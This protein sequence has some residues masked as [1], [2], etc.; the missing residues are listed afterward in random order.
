MPIHHNPVLR[1][2]LLSC[3]IAAVV[4]SL[5]PAVAAADGL[6]IIINTGSIPVDP[7]L[8]GT[9]TAPAY[10]IYA[11]DLASGSLLNSG[12]ITAPYYGIFALSM[13]G[14]SLGNTGHLT[15]GTVEGHE[16][17]GAWGLFAGSL[18]SGA[19]I[20]NGGT[21][22]VSAS[23]GSSVAVFGIG[24]GDLSGG[25]SITNAGAI[26][27]TADVAGNQVVA[28]G[29]GV[30][31][32]THSYISNGGDIAATARS[33]DGWL[34]ACGVCLN[35]VDG[36][37][38]FNNSGTITASAS[39][40][41]ASATGSAYG[42]YVRELAAGATFINTGTIVA[43]GG[44]ALDIR[45][46]SV[47]GGDGTVGNDGDIRGDVALGGTV[48][49]VN[50]GNLELAAGRGSHVGG[51]Y[52]QVA[53]GQLTVVV[54][55]ALAYGHVDVTGTADL[56]ASG[57]LVVQL[58]PALQLASGTVLAN[59]VT[60]GTL[61]APAG[62]Y[63]IVDASPF[64]RFAAVGDATHVDIVAARVDAAT[65]L[66]GSGVAFT[67]SQ[68]ALVDA[69]VEG[70][71]GPQYVALAG[72]LNRAATA[73]AAAAIVRQLDPALAGAAGRAAQGASQ[74]IGEVVQARQAG[75]GA[76]S[77]DEVA[78]NGVWLKT[79]IGSAGQD[80]VA[81][82][83]GFSAD[84]AGLVLGMDGNVSDDWRLGVAVATA[85]TD[86]D[87]DDARSAVSIDTLQ[88]ALYGHY[89]VSDRTALDVSVDHAVNSIDSIRQVVF[90]GATAAARYDGRQTGLGLGLAYHAQMCS[91]F[92]LTPGVSLR[93]QQLH[94]DG[95]SE[96]G[97]G[98]YD[99][100]VAG[101]SDNSLLWQA[102]LGGEASLGSYG[103]MLANVGV[104]YDTLDAASVTATLSG[105]GPTFVS[106]G[107]KPEST[108]LNAGVG[109]RFMTAKGFEINALYERED[110]DT[111]TADTA[112]LKFRMPF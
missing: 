55:D 57:K 31:N 72:A 58:A 104:G 39:S 84:T 29:V 11:G 21:I 82:V 15:I 6:S 94:L 51:N 26:T 87:A 103:T 66:A 52:T 107:A 46:V 53:G 40:S 61:V 43:S 88:L 63:E 64:W 71:Y 19:A 49:L 99:L 17:D 16:S 34:G 36:A 5:V 102:R 75:T 44:D 106:Q 7:V 59:V 77:G 24:A 25:S 91:G 97:S 92:T 68:V 65:A 33:G 2:S 14:A 70:A 1:R 22:D 30:G 47:Y 74:R 111:F 23:S 96:T 38:T 13:T 4:A 18:A 67:G 76:A 9:G 54:A 73:P 90:A 89:A 8:V 86:A 105:T 45:G 81:G 37:S 62:S 69:I 50:S 95:Y 48:S 12:N 41:H 83:D 79:F 28:Y 80:R 85:A 108:V 20:S 101:R 32:L 56:G 109:Y 98:V 112:S 60:A 110:R 42:V 35:V 78:R 27:A 10:G 3:T 93:Y 100:T